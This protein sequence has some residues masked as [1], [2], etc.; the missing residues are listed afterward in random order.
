MRLP[1]PTTLRK[2]FQHVDRIDA[3]FRYRITAFKNECGGQSGVGDVIADTE[4]I[5]AAQGA[6]DAPT[7]Q[8][9]TTPTAKQK[10]SL[11]LISQIKMQTERGTSIAAV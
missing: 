9:T 11:D 10:R 3:Q 2:T 8:I 7:F 1:L 4:K 5:V 6:K